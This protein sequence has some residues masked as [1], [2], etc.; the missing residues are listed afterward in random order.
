[1]TGWQVVPIVSWMNQYK[2]LEDFLKDYP[3]TKEIFREFPRI[4]R[5]RKKIEFSE[6]NEKKVMNGYASYEGDKVTIIED[7][8]KHITLE[9]WMIDSI[10]KVDDEDA[11]VD[12]KV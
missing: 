5:G 7:E 4:P 12:R 10:S 9:P 6:G 8:G 1:M 3:E 2:S 11:E